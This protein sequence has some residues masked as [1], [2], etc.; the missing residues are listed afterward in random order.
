MFVINLLKNN[1]ALL[2]ANTQYKQKPNSP[3]ALIGG[4]DSEKY[5]RSLVDMDCQQQ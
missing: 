1:R 2:P 3:T 4:K 5:N